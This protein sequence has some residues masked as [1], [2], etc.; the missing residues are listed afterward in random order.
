[1]CGDLQAFSLVSLRTGKVKGFRRKESL[2]NYHWT[3][4]ICHFRAGAT[5]R[6]ALQPLGSESEGC[7][8]QITIGKCQ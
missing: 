7:A 8:V 5:P 1:M 6:S 2:V 3:F 4:L